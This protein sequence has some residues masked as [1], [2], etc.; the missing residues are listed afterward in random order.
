MKFVF[1]LPYYIKTRWSVEEPLS[2]VFRVVYIVKYK[3]D[4]LP[5]LSTIS[6]L[7]ISSD[8]YN[9]LCR[10]RSLAPLEFQ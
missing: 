7:L 3:Q 5:S 8:F 4:V 2:S 9:V 10:K 6:V 1:K